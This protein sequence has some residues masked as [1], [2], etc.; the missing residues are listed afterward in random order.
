MQICFFDLNLGNRQV[1]AIFGGMY[2]SFWRAL[3]R[4][5]AKVNFT[6]SIASLEGDVL[7]VALGEGQEVKSARA[8]EA[9]NGPVIVYVPP[10]YSWFYSAFLKR[11]KS[12]IIFAYGT[13][14][15]DLS[16]EKYQRL[17]IPYYHV[18][19][20]SDEEI[21]YPLDLPKTYDVIFVGNATSGVGRYRYTKLL[22]EKAK[23]KNWEILLI[24][25]GWE[26]YGHPFQIV[27]H[28]KLLNIIYNLGKV[29]LNVHN[30]IQYSGQDRQMDANNR[31]F[32][33]AMAGCFQI[34]NAKDLIGKYFTEEEV[35]AFDE[36]VKLI[37]QIDYFLQHEDERAEM[38]RRSM[39]KANAQH[40]WNNRAS[41]F[42]RVIGD[43]YLN[44][45]ESESKAGAYELLARKYDQFFFPPYLIKQKALSLLQR[46]KKLG[47]GKSQ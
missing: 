23:E 33:L 13:D 34:N 8:M 40:T 44:W 39:Q 10:A 38:S 5:G 32:D 14:S 24:G 36:P 15:S 4:N 17:G 11:W 21:F 27:A 25:A 30:D 35:V 26:R 46:V 22:M 7:V 20:A 12:K 1:N 47:A 37:E 6:Q 42:I 3:E 31:V 29:C 43:H 28:G 45:N 16:F 41:D 9:F 2:K 19:F 18:P